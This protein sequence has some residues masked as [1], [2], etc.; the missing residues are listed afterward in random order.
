MMMATPASAMAGPG[1]V[2]WATAPKMA[3]PAPWKVI[4]PVD[5]SPNAW[6]RTG[7]GTAFRKR[8]WIPRT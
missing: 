5:S 1:E 2:L 8:R 4:R 3:G 7:G 6:P